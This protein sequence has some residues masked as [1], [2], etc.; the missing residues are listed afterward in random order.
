MTSYGSDDITRYIFFFKFYVIVLQLLQRP[1]DKS[2]APNQQA[3][4]AEFLDINV[5]VPGLIQVFAK[6]I[7]KLPSTH[8]IYIYKMLVQFLDKNCLKPSFKEFNQSRIAV[9]EA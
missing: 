4:E 5:L 3:S 7:H 6:K 8:A 9:G 1:V 2:G